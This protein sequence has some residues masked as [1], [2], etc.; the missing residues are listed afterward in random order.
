MELAVEAFSESLAT[1]SVVER[2]DLLVSFEELHELMGLGEI[3]RL[4]RR[5]LPAERLAAKYGG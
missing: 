4:E 5:Y 1:G 3:E 2:P